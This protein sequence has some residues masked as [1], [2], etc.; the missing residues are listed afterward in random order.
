MLQRL[1]HLARD[2]TGVAMI[3]FGLVLPLMATM[4]CGAWEASQAVICYMKLGNA[5]DTVADLATQQKSM[6]SSN[7]DDFYTSAQLVL[8]PNNAT[9]LGLA[10]ASVTFDP[11]TGAAAVAWQQTRGGAMPMSAATITSLS[12][13]LGNPGDSVI[14]AQ[15]S[16][17]YTSSLDYVLPKLISLNTTAMQRPRLVKSIPYS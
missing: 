15:L 2:K 12:S 10:I 5:A 9:G 16:Y 13:G 3:E 7:I 17:T 6:K 8:A 14:V 4:F 1:V 11:T